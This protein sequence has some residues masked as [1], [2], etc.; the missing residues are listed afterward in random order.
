MSLLSDFYSG[1]LY[2][3]EEL[4]KH[5]PDF[6]PIGDKIEAEK[7]GWLKNVLSERDFRRFEEKLQVYYYDAHD[8]WQEKGFMYG[9]RLAVMLI[10]EIYTGK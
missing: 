5:N 9:F 6:K 4:N 1:K 3:Y 7:Y 2:P 8:Y 10:A